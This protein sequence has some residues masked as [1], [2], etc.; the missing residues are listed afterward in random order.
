M[1]RKIGLSYYNYKRVSKQLVMLDDTLR[2]CHGIGYIVSKYCV[3]YLRVC[4]GIGYIVSKYC[5]EY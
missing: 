4:H 2:V 5:V 1:L 3:E